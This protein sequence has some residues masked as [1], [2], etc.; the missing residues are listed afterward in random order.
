MLKILILILGLICVKV[1]A[2]AQFNNK[3][4]LDTG[5]INAWTSLGEYEISQ[6][7]KYIYHH[8]E[9]KNGLSGKIILTKVESGKS[10]NYP[11][12]SWCA[13]IAGGKFFVHKDDKNI[14]SVI[15]LK[16]FKIT[17]FNN[18]LYSKIVGSKSNQHL[19]LGFVDKDSALVFQP[20]TSKRIWLPNSYF[21]YAHEGKDKIVMKV[22]TQGVANLDEL[23]VCDLGNYK[24]DTIWRGNKINL[25]LNT[26][27]MSATEGLA[28]VTQ[29]LDLKKSQKLWFYKVCDKSPS[30]IFTISD[31]IDSNL[32]RSF[33]NVSFD[34]IGKMIRFS[35][36][37]E[38]VSSRVNF[39]ELNIWHYKDRVINPAQKDND[40]E[41]SNGYV[42][43]I[44]DKKVLNV[45]DRLL[46]SGY[47]K[48][49]VSEKQTVPWFDVAQKTGLYII[50]TS[51]GLKTKIL[52]KITS[53]YSLYS[54][55]ISPDGG[56]VVDFNFENLSISIYNTKTWKVTKLDSL[57]AKPFFDIDQ[58]RGRK[59]IYGI[60]GWLPDKQMVLVYDR[61][62]IWIIS[63]TNKTSAK[64]AFNGWGAR[65]GVTLKVVVESGE[66]SIL[67]NTG[68]TLVSGFNET[69]KRGGYWDVN[70][71]KDS[72]LDIAHLVDYSVTPRLA[73]GY[74]WS[75][76]GNIRKQKTGEFYLVKRES[77]NSSSN[78]YISKDLRIYT[79]V[80]KINPENTYNWLTAELFTWKMP[81]GVE[82]K[83]ILYRPERLD[84]FKKYPVIFNY[85]ET[86]SNEFHEFIKPDY[87]GHN[88]NI[89]LF[90][91]NGYLV[92]VPDMH[93]SVGKNGE[94]TLISIESAANFVS[95]LPYVDS[96]KFGLQGHS[97]GGWQTNY[98]VS[99][100]NRFAAAC[101]FAG[102]SNQ[103]S[104]YGQLSFGADRNFFYEQ[105]SQGAAYGINVTP[106]NHPDLYLL[107]SP[108]F[109]V[110][111]VHTPLLMVHCPKDAAVPFAQAIEFFTALRR[112]HK[113]AWLL[114]YDQGHQLYDESAKD[115]HT[116]MMQ[117]FDYYLK[118]ALP[119]KWM[120]LGRPDYLKLSDD[121]LD[122]DISG[123]IP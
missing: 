89:P 63:L 121:R 23:F 71:L 41:N 45:P 114:E 61:Y 2:Y 59:G 9:S 22:K 34:N 115:F 93:H 32:T 87:S 74:N 6:D 19:V 94:G 99:H 102:V 29:D 12:S 44:P 116:R 95:K 97:F 80:S 83:G 64:K 43:S 117:F 65:N 86:R 3:I 7:G 84:F 24:T 46:R 28:F 101:E 105:K 106:Y 10:I 62:D 119:P 16:D 55:F 33:S 92:F 51:T 88:L 123:N 118:G 69:N 50:D 120:T 20:V 112:C 109:N 49:I 39:K 79:N 82:T 66:Q 48:L 110:E 1:S 37:T 73:Q 107:N 77:Y 47:R 54:T 90:I 13:F 91:A 108:V 26:S 67:P 58:E 4:P 70:L 5:A 11:N 56:Y 52:D 100:S 75:T 25:G 31:A 14:V 35:V 36:N 78:I 104:A 111:S 38:F 30:V 21:V 18:V 68:L 15:D 40:P 85:Y 98:I 57:I 81:N 113:K 72:E 53:D 17:T 103:T 27:A 42:Y 8:V 60:A 76:T 96:T 122:F